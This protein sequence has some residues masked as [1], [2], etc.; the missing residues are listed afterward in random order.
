[1]LDLGMVL[2]FLLAV[3]MVLMSPGPTITLLFST[4]VSQ[5][6]SAAL[7]TGMGISTAVFIS[8]LITVFGL[9]TLM[10]TV[11]SVFTAIRIFGVVY[12]LY[13]AFCEW[14]R[15]TKDHN[16]RALPKS[17]KCFWQGFLVDTLN[18]ASLLFLISFLPQFVNPNL[19]HI[20][21]QLLLLSL[22]YT[23]CDLSF[24]VALAYISGKSV[25][26][27]NPSPT[28][29]TVRRYSL[30]VMYSGLAFYLVLRTY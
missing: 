29:M 13:L 8:S 21:V 27:A 15:V 5:G 24:N 18:P 23:A 26:I 20:K 10:T 25:R 9:S 4:G 17:A 7:F 3:F 19:G 2:P 22:L 30:V 28:L 6:V 1:M 14:R 16:T 11:P 12:L